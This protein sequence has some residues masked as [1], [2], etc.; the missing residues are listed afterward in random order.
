MDKDERGRVSLW[1]CELFKTE[2]G[3]SERQEPVPSNRVTLSPAAPLRIIAPCTSAQALCLVLTTLHN[4]HNA[5]LVFSS[6]Q[7]NGLD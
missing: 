3:L 4:S 1:R 7:H 2:L 6:P 5:Q